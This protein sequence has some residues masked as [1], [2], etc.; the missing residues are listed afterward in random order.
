MTVGVTVTTSDIAKGIKV[1]YPAY[2]RNTI[3]SKI[4]DSLRNLE[5]YGFVRTTGKDK[6][7]YRRLWERIM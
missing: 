6:Y 3:I 7:G 5:K 2:P 4:N 1:K